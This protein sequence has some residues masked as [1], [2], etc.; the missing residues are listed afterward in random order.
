MRDVCESI[1][2]SRVGRNFKA[3]PCC[4]LLSRAVPCCPV[5]CP[6]VPCCALLGLELLPADIWIGAGQW[7]LAAM[8]CIAVCRPCHAMHRVDPLQPA[9]ERCHAHHG[10]TQHATPCAGQV[11]A[12]LMHAG[13]RSQPCMQV[14]AELMEQTGYQS[15]A[16]RQRSHSPNRQLEAFVLPARG[17]LGGHNRWGTKGLNGVCG[18]GPPVE[19]PG[20]GGAG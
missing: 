5:L 11:T 7:T 8:P 2:W 16:G 19:Q 20:P 17:T 14:T 3:F 10:C 13:H 9:R 12:K 6:A 1:F 18:N 15:H 4:A